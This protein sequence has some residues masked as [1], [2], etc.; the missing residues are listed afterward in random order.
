MVAAKRATHPDPIREPFALKAVPRH[1]QCLE[2]PFFVKIFW[3]DLCIKWG[4]KAR[5]KN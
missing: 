3:W 5:V 4:E 2:I 1:T